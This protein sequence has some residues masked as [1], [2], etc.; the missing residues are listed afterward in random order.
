MKQ[1]KL[2]WFSI[3]CVFLLFLNGGCGFFEKKQAFRDDGA[4]GELQIPAAWSIQEK[5]GKPIAMSADEKNIIFIKNQP[6]PPE[7]GNELEGEYTLDSY[8]D[9]E[10]AHFLTF[11]KENLVRTGQDIVARE[12]GFWKLERNHQAGVVIF[13]SLSPDEPT[14]LILMVVKGQEMI[15]VTVMSKTKEDFDANRALLEQIVKSLEVKK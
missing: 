9:I 14:I 4:G 1:K 7:I 13:D 6:I 5:H 10:R 12:S 11:F 8:S 15:S 2:I 3:G